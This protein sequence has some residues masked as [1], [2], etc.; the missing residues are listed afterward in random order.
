METQII[1]LYNLESS[2]IKEEFLKLGHKKVCEI[3]CE[4][5][6]W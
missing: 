1:D 6:A 5:M 3:I 4:E 2:D